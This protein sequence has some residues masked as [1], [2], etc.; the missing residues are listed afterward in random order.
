MKRPCRSE[1]E[2][3]LDRILV[4]CIPFSHHFLHLAPVYASML[5]NDYASVMSKSDWPFISG[6]KEWS[7]SFGTVQI[8]ESKRMIKLD[9]KA[10]DNQVYQ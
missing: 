5:G 4:S 1:H 9:M 6:Y 8:H 3:C 2:A 7:H 10:V